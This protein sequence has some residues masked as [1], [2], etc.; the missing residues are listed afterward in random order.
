LASKTGI[1]ESRLSTEKYYFIDRSPQ[2]RDFSTFKSALLRAAVR[3]DLEF[4]SGALAPTVRAGFEE[5]PIPA[6][7]VLGFFSAGPGADGSSLWTEL[8][9]ALEL[10]AA[11][12]GNGFCVPTIACD[13]KVEPDAF[14]VLGR[15]VAVRAK[16]GKSSALVELL[17]HDIVARG[18][19]TPRDK[20]SGAEGA[21]Q[22]IVTPSGR[23]GYIR[24][25]FLRGAMDYRFYF[26]KH[27]GKW[28]LDA[29][30]VGD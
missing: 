15:N 29:F 3:H 20:S 22:A 11:P 8:R 1:A 26:S 24:M 17:S 14:A 13:G 4:L 7:R 30:A 12:A 18:A 16:P 23:K 28:K 27:D 10:G 19:Y 2:D 5:G 9:K 6:A 21:W 25:D